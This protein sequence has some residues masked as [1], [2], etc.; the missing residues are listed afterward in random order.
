MPY[1]RIAGPIEEVVD[2]LRKLR[3]HCWTHWLRGDLRG[4]V[5]LVLMRVTDYPLVR[6]SPCAMMINWLT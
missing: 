5:V 3:K 6:D 4:S 1:C 2:P